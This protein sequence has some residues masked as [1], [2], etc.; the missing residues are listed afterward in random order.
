MYTLIVANT[1]TSRIPNAIVLKNQIP[2]TY[3]HY[4]IYCN[5]IPNE[6]ENRSLFD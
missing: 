1:I 3:L 4:D 2:R 6:D 5:L